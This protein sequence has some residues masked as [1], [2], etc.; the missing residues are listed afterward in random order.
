MSQTHSLGHVTKIPQTKVT[1]GFPTVRSKQHFLSFTLQTFLMYLIPLTLKVHSFDFHTIWPRLFPFYRSFP[2]SLRGSG[3]SHSPFKCCFSGFRPWSSQLH[4]GI[5]HGWSHGVSTSHVQMTLKS[6]FPLRLG[7]R[8][9]LPSGQLIVDILRALQVQCVQ[10][11]PMIPLPSLKFFLLIGCISTT[12]QI[13]PTGKPWFKQRLSSSALLVSGAAHSFLRGDCPVYCGMSG[14]VPGFNPLDANNNLPV[15]TTKNVSRDCQISSGRGASNYS[16]LEN[17]W[18]K[19][20]GLGPTNTCITLDYLA[21]S[22]RFRW[23]SL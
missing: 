7:L 17:H 13:I 10:T 5:L 1:K 14:S 16:R 21:T 11:Q 22:W 4:S 6:L 9:Q 12:D 8:S 15:E 23:F 18:V 20:V 2:V 3:S 19:S